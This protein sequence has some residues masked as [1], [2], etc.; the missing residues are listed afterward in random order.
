MNYTHAVHN[1]AQEDW[2]EPWVQQALTNLITNITGYC[3]GRRD[4]EVTLCIG[5]H[6]RFIGAGY[7]NKITVVL[8]KNGT[9]DYSWTNKTKSVKA[10][11]AVKS[12]ASGV[13]GFWKDIVS[14]VSGKSP[15]IKD[16]GKK[17]IGYIP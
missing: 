6:R 17:A 12:V 15:A 2:E 4:V 11:E 10:Q 1:L 13:K 8:H 5:K 14:M 16:S 9:S 7:T 3:N